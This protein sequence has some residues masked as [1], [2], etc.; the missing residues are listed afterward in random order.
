ML[1]GSINFLGDNNPRDFG[2][3]IIFRATSICA[4]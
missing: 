2:L 1:D 4:R 3:P